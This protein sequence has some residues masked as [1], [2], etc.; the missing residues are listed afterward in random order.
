MTKYQEEDDSAPDDSLRR[1]VLAFAVTACLLCVVLAL[2]VYRRREPSKQDGDEPA[3]APSSSGPQ[4]T[5]VT[6]PK[7]AERAARRRRKFEILRRRSVKQELANPSRDEWIYVDAQGRP[8]AY[9]TST[10]TVT[11]TYNGTS[12]ITVTNTTTTVTTSNDAY[13]T[14]ARHRSSQAAA[15]P[16][17]SQQQRHTMA[18]GSTGGDGVLLRNDSEPQKDRK[19]KT[20]T[21][22]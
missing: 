10:Q 15:P 4:P 2:S 5:G 22:R 21:R 17:Q 18:L 8:V 20:T 14:S 7:A 1:L 11:V 3:S 6:D 19:A 9:L 16:E 13:A 12:K